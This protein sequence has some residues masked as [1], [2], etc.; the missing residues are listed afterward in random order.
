[1]QREP[2][3]CVTVV[4]TRR[5]MFTQI[6]SIFALC[7]TVVPIVVVG[8]SAGAGYQHYVNPFM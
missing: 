4:A 5:S 3:V 1:M 8:I 7:T 2:N 6:P